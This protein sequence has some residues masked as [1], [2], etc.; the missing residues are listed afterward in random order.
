MIAR[1]DTGA[2]GGDWTW[3]SGVQVNAAAE[4]IWFD[5]HAGEDAVGY[6]VTHGPVDLSDVKSTP[7]G[8]YV[9]L[10]DWVFERAKFAGCRR[11]RRGHS[12]EVC[13]AQALRTTI[14]TRHLR[15][16]GLGIRNF[17]KAA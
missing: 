6:E 10:D 9:P 11:D 2:T 16:P 14:C 12:V 15:E 5:H 3:T 1:I 7:P 4:V 13:A 17:R 8:T